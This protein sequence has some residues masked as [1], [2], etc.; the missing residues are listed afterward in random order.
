MN[1]TRTEATSC[2]RPERAWG[3]TC[4]QQGII[5]NSNSDYSGTFYHRQ[6]EGKTETT[7]FS[8]ETLPAGTFT[9]LVALFYRQKNLG[10]D[11]KRCLSGRAEGQSRSN[12]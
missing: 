6:R 8:L 12:D 11:P 5:I 7:A 9:N 1:R 10:M 2:E 4:F 3:N